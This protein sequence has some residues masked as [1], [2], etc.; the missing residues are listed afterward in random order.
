MTCPDIESII[1]RG[2]AGKRGLNRGMRFILHNII[3]YVVR[4][5]EQLGTKSHM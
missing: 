1:R 4:I 3:L 5:D 2:N